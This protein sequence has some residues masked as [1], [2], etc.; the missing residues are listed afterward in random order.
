MIQFPALRIMVPSPYDNGSQHYDDGSQHYG[1]IL[2]NG[3]IPR[4]F[5]ITRNLRNGYP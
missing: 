3:K 2:D 1:Q 4:T 5:T